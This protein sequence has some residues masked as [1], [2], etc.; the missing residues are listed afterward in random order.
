MNKWNQFSLPVREKDVTEGNRFGPI[1][2]ERK[3]VKFVIIND[4]MSRSEFSPIVMER[5][6]G[7][8]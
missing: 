2:N 8:D 7:S 1:E 4:L 3:E 6:E 5:R